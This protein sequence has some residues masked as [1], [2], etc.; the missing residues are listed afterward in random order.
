MPGPTIAR[1]F[2][3]APQTIS[4]A[5]C[6]FSSSAGDLQMTIS[7]FRALENLFKR[8]AHLFH[9]SGAVHYFEDAVLAVVVRERFGLALVGGQ[10]LFHYFRPIVRSLHQLAAVGIADARH[11]RR[12]LK[13]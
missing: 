12:T 13:N 7:P 10:S 4:P 5:R 6:I 11:F 8:A 1:I 9:I 2:S 3:S